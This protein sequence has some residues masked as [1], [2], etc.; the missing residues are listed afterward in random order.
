M[1]GALAAVFVVPQ[2]ARSEI[3]SNDA[4]ILVIMI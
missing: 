2:A 3:V 1:P 4:A